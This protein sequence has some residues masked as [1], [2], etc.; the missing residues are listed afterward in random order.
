MPLKYPAEWKFD[1]CGYEIPGAADVEFDKLIGVIIEGRENRRALIEEFKSA[2][3]SSVWSSDEGWAI[4]DLQ[5]MMTGARQNAARYL[6]CFYDGLAAMAEMNI[7]VPGDD[8]INKILA[9]HG[10]PLKIQNDEIVLA[11]G[12]YEVVAAGEEDTMTSRGFTKGRLLGKGGFGEVYEMI[13]TTKIGEYRYAMKFFEPS[14]FITDKERAGQRFEKEMKILEKLQHRGI[15]QL[16]EAGIGADQKPYILM[17]YIEGT[18]IKD[19]LSGAAPA[20]V[21]RTFDEVLNALDFAHKQSVIHRDLKPNNILIRASDGQP[22]ILDFG[23]AYLLED[24]DPTLTTTLIGTGAYVPD[25][26]H[27]DPK[28]RTVKQDVYACGMLLYQVIVGHLPSTTDYEPLESQVPGYKGLDAVIQRAIAPEKR[29]TATA[30]DMR[31][32]LWHVA[33]QIG[34]RT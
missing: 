31:E 3:G 23:A 22:Q 14:V 4:T 18:D 16:L 8:T 17:P 34:R 6:A 11:G 15:V 28:N 7:P 9:K 32:E 26:V 20:K 13:R 2:Y 30:H 25:E 24:Q 27:R 5:R 33:D 29:R 19:A 12:D 21:L 10:V 1:G